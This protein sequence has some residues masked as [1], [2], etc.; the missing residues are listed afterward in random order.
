MGKRSNSGDESM[1][2]TFMILAVFIQ[3]YKD[4][5]I[6]SETFAVGVQNPKIQNIN[7][8]LKIN[9]NHSVCVNGVVFEKVNSPNN[10]YKD[11]FFALIEKKNK[12]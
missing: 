6:C 11:V 9:N 2:E 3:L 5:F 12:K 7:N 4:S 10:T 8:G 1:G